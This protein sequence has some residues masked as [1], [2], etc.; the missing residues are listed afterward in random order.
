MIAAAG[1]II[2]FLVI[3]MFVFAVGLRGTAWAAIVKDVLV[4]AAVITAGIALPVHF[5]GSPARAITAL[6]SI[7]PDWL[8]L[9]NTSEVNGTT[10]FVST[11]LLS[12]LGFFMWP[13]SMAA[14][15]SARDVQ[16]LRRNAIFLP[17]YQL[18][19]LPVYLAG[20]TALLVM[21][22]LKGPAGDQAFMLVLQKYYSPW[23]VGFVAAAGCL[24]ALVPAAAQTLAAASIVSKNVLGDILG[25]ATSDRGRTLATRVL[26]LL[27][28]IGALVVWFLLKTQLVS[29]LLIGYN[30]ITQFFPGVLFSLYWRRVTAWAAGLGICAGIAV[31][32]ASL[33]PSFQTF[34]AGATHGINIGFIALIINALV[35]VLLSLVTPPRRSAELSRSDIPSTG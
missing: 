20:F 28:A 31:L 34:A 35:C 15:Y 3:A 10:W 16:S 17:A 5:F 22:G 9:K 18:V 19:L 4:L 32:V 27:V 7:K 23:M 30:G 13:T 2:A 12:A 8:T 1:V 6:L 11:V 25:L 26:V 29:F 24:A 21:P 14:T 33:N